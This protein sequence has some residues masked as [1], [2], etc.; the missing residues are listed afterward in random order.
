MNE[1]VKIGHWNM[2]NTLTPFGLPPRPTSP[3]PQP[4]LAYLLSLGVTAEE[5]PALVTERPL[6]LGEGID[7]VIRF[8]RT[9]GMARTEVHRLLGSYPIDYRVHIAQIEPDKTEGQEDG[10]ATNPA[11]Q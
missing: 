4:Q 9:C 8:L 6:V 5:L 11:A 7:T 10:D 2:S 3:P 1:S